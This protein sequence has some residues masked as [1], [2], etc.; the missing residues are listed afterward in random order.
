MAGRSFP[1]QDLPWVLTRHEGKQR[2]FPDSEA[3]RMVT[4][5]T[6]QRAG[7]Q[8]LGTLGGSVTSILSNCKSLPTADT[9]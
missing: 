5:T 3:L 6:T 2:D 4:G 1:A 8:A 9:F 7:E